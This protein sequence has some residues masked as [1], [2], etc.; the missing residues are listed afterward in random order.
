MVIHTPTYHRGRAWRSSQCF[1]NLWTPRGRNLYTQVLYQVT[2]LIAIC[3]YLHIIFWLLDDAVFGI[4]LDWLI[5]QTRANLQAPQTGRRSRRVSCRGENLTWTTT[6]AAAVGSSVVTGK[7]WKTGKKS[8]LIFLYRYRSES[9]GENEYLGTTIIVHSV[10][11]STY[12]CYT[13]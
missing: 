7:A 4:D 10:A 8:Y 13:A 6:T 2:R 1:R 12:M 3:Y 5:T 11:D 9:R